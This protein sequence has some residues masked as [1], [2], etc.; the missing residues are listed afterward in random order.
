M[1][2]IKGSPMEIWEQLNKLPFIY[3]KI[4]AQQLMV[5]MWGELWAK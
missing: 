1:I 4:T 2:I 3:G 5:E